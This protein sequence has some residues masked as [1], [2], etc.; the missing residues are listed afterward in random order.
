M[1]LFGKRNHLDTC[2]GYQAPIMDSLIN[3]P[4]PYIYIPVLVDKESISY[5]RLLVRF[6]ACE[7]RVETPEALGDVWVDGIRH[8]EALF[9]I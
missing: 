4:L 5:V 9:R 3:N 7:Y 1:L 2:S 8:E 6:K